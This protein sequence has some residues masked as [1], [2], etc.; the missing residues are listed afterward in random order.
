MFTG[1]TLV[2]CQHNT[3]KQTLFP[4]FHNHFTAETPDPA[5]DSTAGTQLRK[6]AWFAMPRRCPMH[7]KNK[8]SRVVYPL[9]CLE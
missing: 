1:V 5:E 2:N 6:H 3:P 4:N 7:G 8:N 9:L